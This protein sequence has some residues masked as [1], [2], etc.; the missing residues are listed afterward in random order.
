MVLIVQRGLA[1]TI[2]ARWEGTR[3]DRRRVRRNGAGSTGAGSRPAT[4]RAEAGARAVPL[5]VAAVAAA[6][7]VVG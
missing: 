5:V 1:G 7:V 2:A 6:A 3:A 4:A